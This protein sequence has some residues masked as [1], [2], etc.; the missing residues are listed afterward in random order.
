ML[1][2]LG[3]SQSHWSSGRLNEEE[4]DFFSMIA[5]K[6]ECDKLSGN[7]NTGEKGAAKCSSQYKLGQG[8]RQIPKRVASLESMKSPSALGSINADT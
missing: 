8:N 5:G 1:D 3:V 6:C 7:G 2:Q 4:P